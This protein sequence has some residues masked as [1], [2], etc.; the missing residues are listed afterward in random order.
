MASRSGRFNTTQGRGTTATPIVDGETLIVWPGRE[1][2]CQAIALTMEGDELKEE[3]L[4]KNTENTVRFNTPVLKDG[5]VFGLTT[6]NTLFCINTDTHETAWSPAAGRARTAAGRRAVWAGR[7]S[8][9]RRAGW[10][11]TRR[12]SAVRI[13]RRTR[14]G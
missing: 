14:A 9:T 10:R 11:R 1:A 6:N 5:T 3:E 4:W 12:S 7:R 2:G 13:G 8:R